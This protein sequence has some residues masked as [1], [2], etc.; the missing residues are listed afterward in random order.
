MLRTNFKNSLIKSFYDKFSAFSDTKNYIFLG[1][2]TEWENDSTP[3]S[4][5]D[6]LAE[7]LNAWRNMLVCKKI[8]QDDVVFVVRRINW[9]VNTVYDQYDDSIELFSEVTPVNFYVMT[10]EKN[11]YKC[12]NNNGGAEST[13]SP[14]GTSTNEILTSDG[15]I[16]KYV[17]S[18]RPELEDFLTDDYIPVEYL[19]ELSYTDIRSLQ[20]DV[21]LD[22][23]AN[24]N[25]SIRKIEVTQTGSAYPFAIDY[26]V[27]TTDVETSHNVQANIPINTNKIK[28]NTL[29]GVSQINDIFNDNYIVYIYS[30]K[31]SG[32]VRTIVDYD[33][34]TGIATVSPNFSE[35]ITTSSYY[36]ILPK[37]E[38]TG[39]GSGAVAICNIN[40]ITKLVTSISVISGGVNYKEAYATVY[41]TRT[42]ETEKTLLR[43]AISPFGGHGSNSLIELGCKNLMIKTQFD[44][45]QIKELNFYNDYR[46]VG[47]IQDIVVTGESSPSQTY[48]LNIENL[49]ATTELD[50]TNFD[51]TFINDIIGNYNNPNFIIKQGSNSNTAQAQGYPLSMRTVD[52]KTTVVLRTLNGKFMNSNSTSYPLQSEY[53]NSG[54]EATYPDINII[55]ASPSNYYS[56]ST[57]N[58]NDVVMGKDSFSTAKVVKWTPKFFGTDGE[59]KVKDLKGG[60]IESYYT[61]FGTLVNGEQ[62]IGFST[63][64]TSSS[65]GIIGYNSS[66]VGVIKNISRTEELEGKNIFLATT[67]LTVTRPSGDTTEFSQTEFLEDDTIK[68]VTTGSTGTVVGWVLS[69]NNLTGTLI[70]SHTFGSFTIGSNK[71]QRLE[72]GSYTTKEVV[73]SDIKT[74]EVNRYSGKILYIENIRPVVR[75][76]DQTEEIKIVIGL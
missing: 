25:G 49:N 4:A 34:S 23:K 31:G 30:G 57:F 55:K 51:S 43:V 10:T 33:G 50:I 71:I 72:N 58:M 11:V 56:D 54:V 45:E 62:L 65:T 52:G 61:D 44:K 39:N 2:V 5:S 68:Q 69:N 1:K 21:E 27:M 47:I 53:L 7:E 76:D 36:K 8:N 60:F 41:T 13:I 35:S 24:K 59:L 14:S 63:I 20:L 42:N 16:W 37:V 32:Q 15:Y 66:K 70:L 19:D 38:I 9:T 73:V 48:I 74:P 40:E 67:I 18:V 64:N 6:S 26:S 28:F 12:I 3:P 22:A 29:A 46:Q 75:S 17:Y